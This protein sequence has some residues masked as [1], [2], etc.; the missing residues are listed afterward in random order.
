MTAGAL[1]WDWFNTDASAAKPADAPAADEAALS[2]AFARC[3]SGPDGE[4]VLDYL[5]SMTVDR[6]LGPQASDMMLRHLE[7]QRFLVTHI[8]MLVDRGRGKSGRIR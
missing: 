5:R 2:K 8:G 6:A 4:L 3:L 1:G 7:G